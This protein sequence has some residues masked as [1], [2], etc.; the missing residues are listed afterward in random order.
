MELTN[1][2]IETAKTAQDPQA[3]R[4]LA[5]ERGIDL[6]PE[7][8]AAE[9]AALHPKMGALEDDELDNIAGGCG[10][11]A[12]LP[13]AKY[14]K[15]QWLRVLKYDNSSTIVRVSRGQVIEMRYQKGQWQYKLDYGWGGAPSDFMN[16]NEL[17]TV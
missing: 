2:L 9:Y 3:L 11:G 8:A 4:A 12:A 14:K 13:A 16:E 10:G 5:R 7:Q 6:T 15:G 17:G 1:E